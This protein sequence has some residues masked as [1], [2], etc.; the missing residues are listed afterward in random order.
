MNFKFINFYEREI[1]FKHLH[2]ILTTRLRLYNIKRAASPNCER[3]SMIEDNLHMFS[4]CAKVKNVVSYFKV[5]VETVCDVDSFN[6]RDVLYLQ[7]LSN[8]KL[9]CNTLIVLTS[10]LV[11][12]IW[13]SRESTRDIDVSYFKMKLLSHFKMLL[14]IPKVKMSRVFT[15]K[16][17]MLPETMEDIVYMRN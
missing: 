4:E 6:M 16:Y 2:G 15:E 14:L 11:G 7:K 9:Q 1:L 17:C 12:T 13:L 8:N 3:C 5:L 10:T